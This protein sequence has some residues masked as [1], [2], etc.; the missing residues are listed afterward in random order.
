MDTP[1]FSYVMHDRLTK[2]DEATGKQYQQLH[3]HIILPGTVPSLDRSREPFY[4]RSSS[5]HVKLLKSISDEKFSAALDTLVGPSWHD[6][7]PEEP[8]VT[9]SLDIP[10]DEPLSLAEGSIRTRPLADAQA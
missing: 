10:R 5:G 1:E 8:K 3:T 6:L 4:N 2:P 7:R 9:A